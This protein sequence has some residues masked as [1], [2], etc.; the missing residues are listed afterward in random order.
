MTQRSHRELDSRRLLTPRE[1]AEFLR[2][3]PRTVTRLA[4]EGRLPGVR[5][6]KRWRFQPEALAGWSKGRGEAA[7]AVLTGGL[8]S[9][10][11]AFSLSALLRP[12]AVICDL[13]AGDR[14]TALEEIVETLAGVGILSERNLF[15]KLLMEREDLM[16]TSIAAGVAVPHPRRAVEGMFE[17]S[18]VAVA[19]SR[20]G[21]D[22]GAASEVPV[23]VFFVIC[24]VDDRWHLRI[25]ARLSRLL[26]ETPIVERILGAKFPREVTGA[27]AAQE[28][29]L[30]EEGLIAG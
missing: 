25:L 26:I 6:G 27:V 28:E 21:V 9:S 5:I 19:I 14:R 7:P 29:A 4:R 10:S 18:T 30:G 12:D 23:R 1:A 2:L 3:N 16:S 24:A 8:D 20:G 11:G 13:A 22:F 17:H 15:L